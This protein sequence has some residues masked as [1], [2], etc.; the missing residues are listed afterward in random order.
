MTYVE[1]PVA[2][3]QPIR[4]YQ[5]D[6][7]QAIVNAQPTVE[8]KAIF[9]LMYGTGL[10]PI[11]LVGRTSGSRTLPPLTRAEFNEATHEVRAAGTKAHT[12]D[13]TALIA[14]WAW[15]YVEKYLHTMLPTVPL[16]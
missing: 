13:R 3:K 4:F 14:E 12:R 5:L 9:A 10:E 6:V 11:V 1:R 2:K 15:P 7:V 8:R 16:F